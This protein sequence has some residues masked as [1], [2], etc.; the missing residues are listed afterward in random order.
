V[1]KGLIYG[2]AA[3]VVIVV[4]VL[5]AGD[6]IKAVVE[7][8]GPRMTQSEV[9]LDKVELLLRS[10]E[11]DLSG[12]LIGNPE[13]FE[14]PHA[15]KLGSIRVKIDTGTIGE[16]T[17][18]IKEILVNSPDVIAE[19]GKFSFNPLKTSDSI[20]RSLETSNFIAIQKNVDAYVKAKTS[21]GN[22]T[23]AASKS[24]DSTKGPKLI[25]EKFRMTNVKV[26]AVSQ[27]GLKLDTSLPPFSI[28]LDNIGKKEN[29]LPPEGIAAVLIPEI[30]QAVTDAITGDLIKT[31]TGLVG[32]LGNTAKH[33]IRTVTKGAS[34][35]GKKLTEGGGT[36][37]K[38]V[39][40]GATAA[41]KG[42]FGK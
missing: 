23:S 41:I 5:R 37:G 14:T 20:Q 35:I 34:D 33:G 30:R 13:G 16:D 8:L 22:G 4:M 29:G 2:G 32:K 6:V 31:T 39:T 36:I 3:V 19:F 1:E 38:S 12:L 18:V 40:E 42:L 15:F 11:A 9:T 24:A 25:I 17:I 21:G 7:E 10:G 27:D 28:P 26:R